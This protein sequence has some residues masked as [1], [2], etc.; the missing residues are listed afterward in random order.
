MLTANRTHIV[1]F[2]KRKCCWFLVGF[3]PN[4][5]IKL[6]KTRLLES[7]AFSLLKFI[8]VSEELIASFSVQTIT[9][10]YP[11]EN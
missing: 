1:M 11:R 6:L 9:F 4:I 8:R 3:R 2:I 10:I 5:L 7:I